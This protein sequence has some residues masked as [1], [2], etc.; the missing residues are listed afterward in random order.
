VYQATLPIADRIVV[1]EIREAFEGDTHAPEVG[2][3]PDSVGAWQESSTGLQYR[4]LT[5][6]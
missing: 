3:T 1:T 5:W 2:R 6:G 4:V